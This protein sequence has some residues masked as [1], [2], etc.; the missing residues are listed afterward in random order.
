M[1]L[2][3][4]GNLIPPLSPPPDSSQFLRAQSAGKPVAGHEKG[5]KR[6]QPDTPSAD[7]PQ[8]QRRAYYD[9]DSQR[10]PGTFTEEFQDRF[11][12]NRQ[13]GDELFTKGKSEGKDTKGT[14]TREGDWAIP[15]S[16]DIHA[17]WQHP[18]DSNWYRYPDAH[19]GSDWR[20]ASASEWYNLQ[21]GEH[22][23]WHRPESRQAEGSWDSSSWDHNSQAN[24]RYNRNGEPELEDQQ[25]EWE[26][27][28]Q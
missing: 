12:A 6:G 16:E 28:Q 19:T 4:I 11:W 20:K 18:D 23:D 8:G 13:K 24:W 7:Q 5:T 22:W 14:L 15:K 26:Y 27:N 21:S 17:D 25:T 3:S 10:E 1:A 9:A 2:G